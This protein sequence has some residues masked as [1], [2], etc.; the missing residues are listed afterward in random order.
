VFLDTGEA[1]LEEITQQFQVDPSCLAC[2]A[3]DEVERQ[4][5]RRAAADLVRAFSTLDGFF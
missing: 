1:G 2:A 5:V 4:S 3:D